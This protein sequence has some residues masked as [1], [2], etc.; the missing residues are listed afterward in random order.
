MRFII[1]LTCT[2]IDRATLIDG[3]FIC[4]SCGQRF[5]R[6]SEVEAH[7]REAHK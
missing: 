3:G 2:A 6:L 7:K 5:T 4:P 1:W